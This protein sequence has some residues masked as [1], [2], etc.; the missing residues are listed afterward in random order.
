[1]GNLWKVPCA[2]CFVWTVESKVWNPFRF[3][4]NIMRMRT[5]FHFR[6][7]ILVTDW[8]R[9]VS[10]KLQRTHILFLIPYL[11]FLSPLCLKSSRSSPKSRSSSC[12][13]VTRYAYALLHHFYSLFW[14][15]F[16]LL[17]HDAVYEAYT[18]RYVSFSAD[19][20]SESLIMSQSFCKFAEQ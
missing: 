3:G 16:F 5:N 9:R 18:E 1:M 2:P 19:M 11:S 8:P 10:V 4:T 13:K 12:A 20:N 7:K 15:T 6:A 14:P 17:V